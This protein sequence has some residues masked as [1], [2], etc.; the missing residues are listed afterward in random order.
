MKSGVAG[1]LCVPL[2][3]ASKKV[4]EEPPTIRINAKWLECGHKTV[5]IW[6]NQIL[7]VSSSSQIWTLVCALCERMVIKLFQEDN[8][9]CDKYINI[10]I[11]AIGNG[12]VRILNLL[13]EGLWLVTG[14]V[15]HES[16]KIRESKQCK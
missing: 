2:W 10:E 3:W 4:C 14:I 16:K 11:K 1:D 5:S 8:S 7:E 6:E 13:A 9:P 12:V 15:I